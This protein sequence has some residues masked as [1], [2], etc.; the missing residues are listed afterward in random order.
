MKVDIARRP[1]TEQVYFEDVTEGETFVS[2]HSGKL[3]QK[4]G[5]ALAVH[6]SSGKL[7]DDFRQDKPVYIV[8]TLLVRA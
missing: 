4:V 8:P 1:N 3:F 2:A 5:Y 7:H 6:C